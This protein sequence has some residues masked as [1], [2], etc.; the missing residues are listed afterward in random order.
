[1]KPARCSRQPVSTLAEWL[2]ERGIG[3]IRAMLVEGDEALAAK[4]FWPGTLAPGLCVEA[5]LVS[6]RSGARR[7]LARTDGGT[8]MLLDNLPPSVTEGA[9]IPVRITRAP[10]A[11]RGRLKRAQGR[12]EATDATQST[13]PETGAFARLDGAQIRQL[14]PGQFLDERWDEIWHAASAGRIDFPGGSILAT[15]TPAMTVIDI[16]GEGSP[17]EVSLAAIPAIA[18]ALRWFEI[19]GNIG[20]DFPTIEAKKDRKAVD[21]ALAAAL[22]DW[23]HERTAIN[24]FGFVQLVARLEG[25]SLLHRFAMARTGLCARRALRVAERTSGAGV[26][27]L[28]VHP[29]LNAK[30]RPEWLDELRRRTGREVRIGID[31]GLALEAPSAQIVAA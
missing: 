29:A 6:K 17:R 3:E 24:G 31:P 30:L 12:F 22:A 2:V 20:I 26:T 23:P 10:I 28:T 27:L 5:Q 15:P 1:M 4:L 13:S 25:P 21:H 18:S 11:E 16:D 7:G 9:R 14:M 8:E 19:G